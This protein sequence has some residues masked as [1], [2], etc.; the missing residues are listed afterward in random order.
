M[1]EGSKKSRIQFY[2]RVLS[3]ESLEAWSCVDI[4]DNLS[5]VAVQFL[6]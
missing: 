4:I 3:L 5:K 6:F 2:F 1:N